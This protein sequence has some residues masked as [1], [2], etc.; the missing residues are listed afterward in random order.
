MIR[1][2]GML[3]HRY[4]Q[5]QA[6]MLSLPHT[7]TGPENK[8]AS[9]SHKVAGQEYATMPKKS[10]VARN[11]AQR[12]RP[13]VQKS[14]ELVRQTIEEDKTL[15]EQEA[16]AEADTEGSEEPTTTPTPTAVAL[17]VPVKSTKNG[18]GRHVASMV[19]RKKA[20]P[21]ITSPTSPSEDTSRPTSTAPTGTV[22]SRLAARRQ[23]GQRGQQRGAAPL[24][25][26]EHYS[27]VRKDLVLIA[28][29]A[30]VMFSVLII[31]HF[32]PAIGG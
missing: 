4:L 31:L 30:I 25:V 29:I 26:S 2:M 3:S 18:S 28:I 22:A 7:V 11:K 1:D 15:V 16:E 19:S 13:R 8:P 10:A 14:I 17:D 12:N 27:Y 20:S 21:Q 6:G 32:V 23:S 24:V 9:L 5:Q